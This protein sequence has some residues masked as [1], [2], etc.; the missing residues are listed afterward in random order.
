M[1]KI[2]ILLISLFL[3][4]GCSV[5]YFLQPGYKPVTDYSEQME[6]LRINFPEIYD[7]YRQGEVVLDEMYQYN[8]K[9]GTP[10]VHVSYHMRSRY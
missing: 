7:L 10:K 8:D 9:D 6:L 2:L 1:K 3:F 5:F 4:S